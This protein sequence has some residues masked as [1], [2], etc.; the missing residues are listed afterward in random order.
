MDS[1]TEPVEEDENG[2]WKKKSK[3]EVEAE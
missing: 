1:Q 3:V 2:S